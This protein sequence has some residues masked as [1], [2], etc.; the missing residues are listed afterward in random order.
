M[1]EKEISGIPYTKDGRIASLDG[2]TV[3]G[4]F[5][6]AFVFH[7]THFPIDDFSNYPFYKYLG[8][9]YKYGYLAVEMLFLISGFKF[10]ALYEKQIT[11]NKITFSEFMRKRFIRLYPLFAITVI[12]TEILQILLYYKCGWYFL[13]ET[14]SLYDMVLNLFWINSI[15]IINI[16]TIN[17]P[18]WT[19]PMEVAMYIIFFGVIK[20]TAKSKINHIK[21]CFY[22]ILLGLVI[23]KWDFWYPVVNGNMARSLISFFLGTILCKFQQ[24]IKNRKK[25]LASTFGICAGSF[26][27]YKTIGIEII[28]DIDGYFTLLILP[29]I[30][31]FCLNSKIII[32]LFSSRIATFFANISYS[33][34]LIH[35]PV[36]IVIAIVFASYAQPLDSSAPSLFFLRI[37]LI[38]FAAVATYYFV[39]SPL[40]RLII[41]KKKMY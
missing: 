21:I 1:I 8:F 18:A 30:F 19:I 16:G 33:I 4:S 32:T 36:T 41:R 20:W 10:M 6:I 17:G 2:L 35:F 11:E 40:N 26:A 3:I 31:L 12:L 15:L 14:S 39:E 22:I 37:L 25:I 38:L 27:I 5:I 34:Y 9:F 29:S 13:H 24:R 28:G 7:Y 23:R